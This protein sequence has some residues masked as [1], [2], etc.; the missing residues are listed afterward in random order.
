[1]ANVL[2]KFDSIHALAH[3]IDTATTSNIFKNERLGSSEG[4]RTF[5]GT[6]DWQTAHGLLLN[7]DTATAAKVQKYFVRLTSSAKVQR[8]RFAP[9]VVG[10][11][12]VVGAYLSGSPKAMLAK[13]PTATRAR[14]ITIVYNVVADGS[15]NADELARRGAVVL[16]AVNAIEGSGVRVNL[17]AA[18]TAKKQND[19][20]TFCT[21]I[22]TDGQKLNIA[23]IAY[24]L[25]NPS[26]LRRHYFRIVETADK[27]TSK[28][29][30]SGYGYV[31]NGN[32]GRTAIKNAG[33]KYNA[34]FDYYEMAD[35]TPE[36][37]AQNIINGKYSL[38]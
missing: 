14:V 28:H 16:A 21:R 37:L 12:P 26:Y 30:P 3:E 33:V 29:W 5:T 31:V 17:Y 15:Q 35:V 27:L 8:P 4:S 22:K 24:P 32:D 38:K 34:C 1:M 20:L 2:K 10:N 11:V 6:A 25:A 18:V 13:R 36:T 23:Q 9:A 7:G 19:T